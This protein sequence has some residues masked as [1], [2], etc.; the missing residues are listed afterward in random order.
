MKITVAPDSFKECLSASRVAEAMAR[1]L[2]AASPRAQVELVPMADGGEGT[3]DALV[4]ATG[5]RTVRTWAPDPLGRPVPAAWGLLGDGRRAVIEMAAASG[6]ER[7]AVHERDPLRTSTRG[8]GT[9]IRAALDAGVRELVVGV[10]GSATVDCG[11]G[12]AAELGA[13]FLD[14]DGRPIEDP[15]GGRLADVRAIELDGLDARLASVRV[16]VACDVTNPLTGP[17]GAAPV[18]APQ[19]GA[20]AAATRR[21]ALG[22]ES[23]AAVVRAATGRDVADLPGAGAAGGL[24]AGLLAFLGAEIRNGARTVIEAVGLRARMAGSA[25]VLTGEGRLDRQSAFGKVPAAVAQEARRAGAPAVAIA[26]AVEPGFEKLYDMGLCAAFSIC[27]GPIPLEEA[28]AHPE[29]LLESA[30]EAVLRLW[31]AAAQRGAD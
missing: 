25:L 12:M 28:M 11:M 10:G 8:T 18:Y 19:K 29:P 14:A 17:D 5:G 4:A 20:D 6:L 30:A 16:T 21:L 26:G 27:R 22:I 13:R 24:A 1:G 3:V 7:L 2:R 31:L 23:F 9:L 15:C